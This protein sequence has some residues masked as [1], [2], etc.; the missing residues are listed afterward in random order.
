[1]RISNGLRFLNGLKFVCA[2]AVTLAAVSGTA[3][4]QVTVV[5][6]GQVIPTN[7]INSIVLLPAGGQLNISTTDPGYT[8]T[9]NVTPGTLAI[10]S[11]VASPLTIDEGQSTNLSWTTENAT[12]CTPSGGAGTWAAQTIGLPD[13]N[14]N[15]TVAAAGTYVFTL[16]CIDGVGGSVNRSA[17]VTA[18]TVGAVVINSFSASPS[19]IE[20]GQSTTLSWTTTNASSCTP[21]GGTGAWSA[22]TIGLPNGSWATTIATAAT[23]VFTLTCADA[24]GG[25]AVRNATVTVNTPPDPNNCAT[26]PLAGSTLTW[27]EFWDAEFP[28]P[29]ANRDD[30]FR[31]AE[32]RAYEFNTANFVDNGLLVSPDNTITIGVKLGAISE[33]PGDFNV[34]P[35]CDHAWGL[36]GGITWA[37]DGKIGA[38]QLQ[39]N[40]TYYFN[41]TFT[42]GFDPNSSTCGTTW[43]TATLQHVNR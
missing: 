32:Y 36:G 38:C 10:T 34:A 40:T 19:T 8:I 6:D 14:V 43:C 20:E 31:R 12:S 28:A 23:Y 13:G 39:P 7:E 37:T 29:G 41:L 22:Q 30:T 4:A 9:R 1:M 33:C 17:T 16:T 18:N 27:L 2:L 3:S 26:P 42:D 15:I 25:S 5:I 35:Q 21:T 11:F 24:S